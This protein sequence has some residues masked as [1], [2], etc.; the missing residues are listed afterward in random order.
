MQAPMIHGLVAEA[1]FARHHPDWLVAA[2]KMPATAPIRPLRPIQAAALQKGR[3]PD[4]QRERAFMAAYT[5]CLVKAAPAKVAAVLA[6]GIASPEEHDATLA[7]GDNLHDC[8]PI[9]AQYVLNV[10]GLRANLASML[11]LQFAT[12]SQPV[13]A[14]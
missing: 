12:Q 10:G 5:G 9:G 2:G 1:M 7:L 8:M 13:S 3:L 14:R 6:T 11:Y 4:A